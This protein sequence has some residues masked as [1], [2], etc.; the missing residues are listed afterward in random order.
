MPV[1]CERKGEGL[2][3]SH[4]HPLIESFLCLTIWEKS[5]LFKH[6]H[7]QGLVTPPVVCV[8]TIKATHFYVLHV[9]NN[10]LL[11]IFS[12]FW[13]CCPFFY[14]PLCTIYSRDDARNTTARDYYNPCVCVCVFFFLLVKKA[15]TNQE[16]WTK[17]WP[18]LVFN[19]Q[20]VLA[21]WW[22]L[23]TR[24]S[25]RRIAVREMF[26]MPQVTHS[27]YNNWSNNVFSIQAKVC[28]TV[29]NSSVLNHFRL[30]QSERTGWYYGSLH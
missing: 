2:F 4:V 30:F 19:F 20:P 5:L 14:N 17:N 9:K 28:L 27:L 18:V 1:C 24:N 7:S 25:L 6:T 10:P 15:T 22:R 26:S 21:V 12:P 23:L 29:T 3:L 16:R 13:S 11:R 8:N